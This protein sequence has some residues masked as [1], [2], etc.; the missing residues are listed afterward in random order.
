MI[1]VQKVVRRV[2]DDDPQSDAQYLQ[3]QEFWREVEA[4]T[5]ALWGFDLG[6]W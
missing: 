4:L 1:E 3:T 6:L 2:D 5:H